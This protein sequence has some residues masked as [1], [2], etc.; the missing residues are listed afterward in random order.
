L[1]LYRIVVM[2]SAKARARRACTCVQQPAVVMSYQKSRKL[3]SCSPSSVL[4]YRWVSRS[5]CPTARAA[6]QAR[7]A[8]RRPSRAPG[9]QTRLYCPS[10]C[11]RRDP[12]TNARL[13]VWR[14]PLSATSCAS[15]R[16]GLSG[17]N[18]N[19]R[20]RYVVVDIVVG[21]VVVT[22][23]VDASRI[24]CGCPEACTLAWDLCGFVALCIERIELRRG[25]SREGVRVRIRGRPCRLKCRFLW[26]LQPELACIRRARIFCLVML[27]ML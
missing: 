23:V 10:S 6:Q 24:H 12:G 18:L 16:R 15:R 21:D 3:I 9:S 26:R 5:A 25:R 13:R 8:T 4:N 20:V 17:N 11:C 1:K 27:L 19:A 2:P 7:V 14:R 22:A